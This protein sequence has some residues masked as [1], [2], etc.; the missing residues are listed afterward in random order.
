MISLPL[1][2]Y[3]LM[4]ALRDRL[5]LS[6]ALLILVG[7]CLSLFVGS[8]AVIESRQAA[9]VFTAA[10]LRFA[11]VVGLV[12]FVVFHVRR[13]FD[14]RDVDY[15]LSR[16]ITRTGFILSHALAFSFLALILSV[17]IGLVVLFLSIG[18]IGVGHGLWLLGLSMEFLI[19]V[20][21]ALFFSMVIS[22]AAG[23]AMS[24]FGLYVLGRLMGD[25]LG[26]ASSN[27]AG[28]MAPVLQAVM[29]VVAMISPRLDLMTQSTW[30]V[31]PDGGHDVGVVF[32]L[33][34]GFV[35]SGLLICAALID[36]RR[37]QF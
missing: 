33:L 26:D 4:A 17:C 32:I 16:P 1:I 2:R 8:S 10:G 13:S 3:V 5:M 27:I 14:T 24:V 37:R 28:A 34:Q 6:L 20:N 12:L 29:N 36:L 30:L 15:L 25:L 18:N 21:A 23:G 19:A 22:S 35:Y 31:Y 7:S 9:L 11:G